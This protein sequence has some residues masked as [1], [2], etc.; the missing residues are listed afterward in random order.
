MTPIA[1]YLKH[2]GLK[3]VLFNFYFRYPLPSTMPW[4][5][6][7][8]TS[9][10]GTRSWKSPS[11]ALTSASRALYPAR[12]VTIS[13]LTECCK[14]SNS[15]AQSYKRKKMSQKLNPS[16]KIS[17]RH[18]SVSWQA[19]RCT[20]KEDWKSWASFASGWV[21]FSAMCTKLTTETWILISIW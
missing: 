21:R 16:R 1:H 10:S 5:K 18:R 20:A 7:W 4:S 15:N 2:L 17:P 13:W 9:C 14:S 12:R 11:T 3:S 6:N 8:P 19:G